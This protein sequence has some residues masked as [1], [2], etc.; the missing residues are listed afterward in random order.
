MDKT[1]KHIFRRNPDFSVWS[2]HDLAHKFPSIGKLISSNKSAF[3]LVYKNKPVLEEL[4]SVDIPTADLIFSLQKASPVSEE[5]KS[6]P[7]KNHLSKIACLVFENILEVLDTS[8]NSFESGPASRYIK[9]I[10]AGFDPITPAAHHI[11]SISQDAIKYAWVLRHQS[12]DELVS[13]LYGYG[14]MPRNPMLDATLKT[15][16]GALSWL[17]E[18]NDIFGLKG[19][20]IN[21]H[22]SINIEK[23][24]YWLYWQIKKLKQEQSLKYKIYISPLPG[25]TQEV[26]GTVLKTC[27]E[28]LVPAFKIGSTANGIHR[29]DKIVL[30][31]SNQHALKEASQKLYRQL[32]QLPAQGVPFTFPVSVGGMLSWAIEPAEVEAESWRIFVAKAIAKS[33]K[34]LSFKTNQLNMDAILN[35]LRLMEIEPNDW[36]KPK[37][38]F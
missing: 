21:Y 24:A 35:K 13:R 37:F 15:N 8:T 18:K 5:I 9:E 20:E 36:T 14:T 17:K 2:Y 11:G 32:H 12:V 38:Y 25:Q 19:F 4:V 29:P 31:F 10:F 1:D 27:N 22:S 3:Y 16:Q 34:L 23:D 30:Y 33:I 28:L 6:L 7:G 26:F